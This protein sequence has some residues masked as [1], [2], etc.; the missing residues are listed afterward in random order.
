[1]VLGLKKNIFNSKFLLFYFLGGIIVMSE[2]FVINTTPYGVSV[3]DTDNEVT[4]ENLLLFSVDFED[5]EVIAEYLAEELQ[6]L[7]NCMNEQDKRLRCV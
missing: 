2:R 3:L 7:V 1:M 5:N 4:D 6:N